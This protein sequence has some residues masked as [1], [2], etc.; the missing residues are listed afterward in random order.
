MCTESYSSQIENA[1]HATT[2]KG[3]DEYE[4][5]CASPLPCH[6][7]VFTRV[8]ILPVLLRMAKYPDIHSSKGIWTPMGSAKGPLLPR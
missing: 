2:N 8:A 3:R 4:V 5:I 1:Y 6:T 7:V